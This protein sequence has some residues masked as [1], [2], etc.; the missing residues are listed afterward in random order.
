[1]PPAHIPCAWLGIV[2]CTP[3]FALIY[4]SEALTS[5]IPSYGALCFRDSE[6]SPS[7]GLCRFIFTPIPFVPT[8]LLSLVPYGIVSMFSYSSYG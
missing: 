3:S 8:L 6:S 5:L 4:N 7:L 2:H 1:M